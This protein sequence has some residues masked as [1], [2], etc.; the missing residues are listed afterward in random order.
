MNKRQIV[1]ALA[2]LFVVFGSVTSA[3]GSTPQLFDGI[4]RAHRDL[5]PG[6]TVPGRVAEVYV[7]EGQAVQKGESLVRLDDR[8]ARER[9]AVLR[10]R[11]ESTIEIES[12]QASLELATNEESR[13]R[14]AHAQ[15]GANEFELRR[16]ELATLQARLTLALRQRQQQEAIS[17]HRR[18]ELALEEFTCRSPIDGIIE[19]IAVE[20]GE[21]VD[22]QVPVVRV[23]R[24]DP[25]VIETTV[26]TA[27]TMGLQIGDAAEIKI[28]VISDG[29]TFTGHI[30]RLSQIADP[31]S[32]T[33]M[34]FIEAE[35]PESLPAGMR[36]SVEFIAR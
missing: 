20:A 8:D 29:R 15:A 14:D 25:L 19:D 32:G 11:A 3:A 31:A 28:P 18:A 7:L 34:V 9:V 23:V 13:V 17:A 30:T 35:N 26:A 4:S 6:F 1:A 16:A 36:V 27:I 10:V 5:H 21:L 22:R 2:C 33:R 12:A 24:A